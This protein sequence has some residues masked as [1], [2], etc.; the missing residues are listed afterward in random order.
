MAA[1][2]A[3]TAAI[4][5]GTGLMKFFEGRKM[6]REAADAIK[7]FE[8]QDLTNPYRT[9]QISTEGAR[10]ALEELNRGTATTMDAVR[11]AGARGIIGATGRVQAANNRTAREIGVNQDEQQVALNMAAAGQDV[12]NQNMIEQRQANELQGYGQMMNVGMGMKYGGLTNIAN[13]AGVF[14]QMTGSGAGGGQIPMTT[15]VSTPV[16][17]YAT[18]AGS[19]AGSFGGFGSNSS[20]PPVY[21]PNN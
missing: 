6:Q 10:L 12:V 8:W 4:G 5:A 3:A 11:N 7:M 13:A 18:G 9:E 2:T 15:P 17:G 20:L 21:I 1:A 14:G 19:Y 16:T